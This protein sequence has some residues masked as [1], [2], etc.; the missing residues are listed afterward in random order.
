MNST[1]NTTA[2]LDGAANTTG[3]VIQIIGWCSFSQVAQTAIILG[4]IAL[5]VACCCC[6]CT[7]IQEDRPNIYK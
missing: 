6:Y 7:A 3:C 2:A 4:F 1:F 5:V